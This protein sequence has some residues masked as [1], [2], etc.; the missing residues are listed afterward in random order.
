MKKIIN[1]CVIV[2]VLLPA[3]SFAISVSYTGYIPS[4]VFPTPLD[5]D[6]P[7]FNQRDV[8]GIPDS[9]RSGEGVPKKYAQ[10]G[11]D[12]D[13][14][15]RSASDKARGQAARRKKEAEA[16]AK[17]ADEIDAATHR[18]PKIKQQQQPP[19]LQEN[20]TRISKITS[21]LPSEFK[22]LLDMLR[23]P[24]SAIP[25]VN[26]H[27]LISVGKKGPVYFL[28]TLG[29][30]S[31]FRL[32]SPL[33][34]DDMRKLLQAE[35]ASLS[36]SIPHASD[37][38]GLGS[39]NKSPITG[40]PNPEYTL[41]IVYLEKDFLTWGDSQPVLVPLHLD[42]NDQKSV[43][44]FLVNLNGYFK[45]HFLEEN[46]EASRVVVGAPGAN[47][48]ISFSDDNKNGI[49][50]KGETHLYI[51]A[52]DNKTKS[53]YIQHEFENSEK[54]N[55][56]AQYWG[57]WYWGSALFGAPKARIENNGNWRRVYEQRLKEIRKRGGR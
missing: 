3:F 50:D 11:F 23:S 25:K 20:S 34:N 5:F 12:L 29:V 16:A 45:V 52:R 57:Y 53:I 22:E 21:P 30:T 26:K 17:I 2:C 10:T 54:M 37:A 24:K 14:N 9:E 39:I 56:Y 1:F 55:Q 38:S 48:F 8:Q 36:A 15:F 19:S 28:D 41:W 7:D 44:G 43:S 42:L 18:E 4:G 32:L 33:N 47:I 31:D 27:P 35:R 46:L 40:M 13:G 49:I 51:L 6:R